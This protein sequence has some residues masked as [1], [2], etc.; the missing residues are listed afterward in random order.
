MATHSFISDY[1]QL[2]YTGMLRF[3][4][5]FGGKIFSNSLLRLTFLLLILYSIPVGFHHQL[6]DPGIST[7]WKSLQVVLTM[8]ASDE[9]R[10]CACSRCRLDSG[11]LIYI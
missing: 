2:T 8:I 6:M 7:F 10:N 5:S 9:S 11:V 1:F 3:P 4:R